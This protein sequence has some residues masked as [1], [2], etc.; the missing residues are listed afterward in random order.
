MI[1]VAGAAGSRTASARRAR[2]ACSRP[3]P[4]RSPEVA[5]DA[6]A[7]GPARQPQLAVAAGDVAGAATGWT[8]P[9][10]PGGDNAAGQIGGAPPAAPARKA[11]PGAP[12][13]GGP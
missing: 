5:P 2:A 6:A 13:G 10:D 3:L 11:P 8:D 1:A 4:G 9:A 7:P 12:R